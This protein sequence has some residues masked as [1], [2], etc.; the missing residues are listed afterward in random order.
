M[1]SHS[2]LERLMSANCINNDLQGYQEKPSPATSGLA[3]DKG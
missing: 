2:E 1:L 3:K